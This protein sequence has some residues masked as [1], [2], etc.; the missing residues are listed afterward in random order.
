LSSGLKTGIQ[1][2]VVEGESDTSLNV[3]E[4]LAQKLLE[5]WN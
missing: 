5:V 3:E 1:V 4:L 2:I